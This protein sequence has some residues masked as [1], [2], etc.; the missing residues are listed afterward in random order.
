V[1]A[2]ALKRFAARIMASPAIAAIGPVKRLE[3]HDVFAARF[4][5]APE[6]AE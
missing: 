4:A 6:A 2:A 1:D 3:R 5:R